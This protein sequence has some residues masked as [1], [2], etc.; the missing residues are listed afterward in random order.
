MNIY[1]PCLKKAYFLE[2]LKIS[3]QNSFIEY[4]QL[5]VK[6]TVIYGIDF[7]GTEGHDEDEVNTYISIISGAQEVLQFYSS[8]QSFLAFGTGA[9]FRE[10]NETTNFFLS[11]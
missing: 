5:G 8:E 10:V 9:I 1:F 6:F 3:K 11:K 7:S 4:I 2:F